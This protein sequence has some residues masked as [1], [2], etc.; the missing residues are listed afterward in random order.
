MLTFK[1]IELLEKTFVTRSHLKKVLTNLRSDIFDKLDQVL[2]EILASRTE[3][4]VLS[5]RVSDHEDRI[6]TLEKTAKLN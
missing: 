3:E 6:S 1:D 2:K 4:K 5:A